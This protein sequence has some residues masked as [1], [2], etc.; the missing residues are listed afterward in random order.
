MAT[1]KRPRPPASN[2]TPTE[3]VAAGLTL[4]ATPIGNLGDLSPRAMEA[5]Q[6]AD[7][8]LVEDTRV[9]GKLQA[10][11]G[12]HVPM[13]VLNEHTSERQMLQYVSDLQGLRGALITDA[14]APGISDPGAAL[15]DLCHERG[16]PV[17]GV[18]GPSAIIA[19]LMVSGFFAQRFA[20]L[21][22]LPRQA[23]ALRAALSPFAESPLTLVVFES[24]FRLDRL[25]LGAADVLPCRRY[26]VCRELTKKHEQ[27]WRGRLPEPPDLAAVPR[28]GEFT[29]VF[30]GARRTGTRGEDGRLGNAAKMP[31]CTDA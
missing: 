10:A 27:V 1:P 21:G 25:I 28:R 16:V 23:G 12:W 18:P 19:A 6:S 13:R 11:F 7:F 8:W 5:L 29:V 3:G 4:V 15:V 24:S 22:F 31:P 9:S 17:V 20:F 30:E 14:G 2:P 26:A